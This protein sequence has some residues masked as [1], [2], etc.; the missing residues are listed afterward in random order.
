MLPSFSVAAVLSPSFIL[1]RQVFAVAVA[2]VLPP[3]SMPPRCHHVASSIS[4]LSLLLSHSL[5]SASSIFI[6]PLSHSSLCCCCCCRCCRI[7]ASVAS[8]SLCRYSPT[9]YVSAVSPPLLLPFCRFRHATP[10]LHRRHLCCLAASVA[11]TVRFFIIYVY[12]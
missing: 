8:V 4:P 11:S 9:V 7:Y 1:P 3:L 5:C 10:S 6:P 12:V 2:V